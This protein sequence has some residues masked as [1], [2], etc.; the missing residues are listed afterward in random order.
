MIRLNGANRSP[1][2]P[3]SPGGARLTAAEVLAGARAP[4]LDRIEGGE[5]DLDATPPTLTLHGRDLLARQTFDSATL[6]EDDAELVVTALR[7]GASGI[8]ISVVD[9]ESGGLAVALNGSDIEVDL[10]G[11]T[12]TV[13]QVISA[14]EGDAG[15]AALVALD[16][17]DGDGS[18]P[19]DLTPDP[20]L[21]AG[22]VGLGFEVLV[23]GEPQD[24]SAAVTDTAV[25]VVVTEL[26]AVAADDAVS[27]QVVSNGQASNAV[28]ITA[29]EA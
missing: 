22:G 26:G 9:T 21:L 28:T 4:K 1:G 19:I 5:L 15:I 16:D 27:V 20:V 17:G 12:P 13:T 6:G 23:G 3:L 8:T 14:L 7:P 29:V 18:D 10:G 25:A 24:V 11:D 2:S